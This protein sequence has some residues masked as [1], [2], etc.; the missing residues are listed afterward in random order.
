MIGLPLTPVPG[1]GRIK[2]GWR[3]SGDGRGWGGETK[4]SWKEA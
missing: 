2:G 1:S 4:G 3:E